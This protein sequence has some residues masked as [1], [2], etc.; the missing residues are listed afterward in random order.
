VYCSNPRYCVKTRGNSV[1]V[2]KHDY[3][4]RNARSSL[5]GLKIKNL[6]DKVKNKCKTVVYHGENDELIT[7]KDK[8]EAIK[9]IPNVVFNLIRKENIDNVI[10]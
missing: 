7:A 3:K 2:I 1:L 8:Y 6:Y 4:I 9:D 10:F 5:K